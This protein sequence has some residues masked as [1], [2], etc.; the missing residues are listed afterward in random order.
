M[1][2]IR[3]QDFGISALIMDSL[4]I[5]RDLEQEDRGKTDRKN[6]I[7]YSLFIFK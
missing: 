3:K 7:E 5:I 6:I 1:E 4:Q 2:I